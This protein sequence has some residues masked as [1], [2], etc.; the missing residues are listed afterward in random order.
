[1]KK[2]ISII[3]YPDG[4]INIEGI[5]NVNDLVR[6][7]GTSNSGINVS[8]SP[9]DTRRKRVVTMPYRKVGWTDEENSFILSNVNMEREDLSSAP[10]L[11]RH[12]KAAILTRI[13]AIRN[14]NRRCMSKNTINK[15]QD[16]GMYSLLKKLN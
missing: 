8:Y 1:M 13:S 15:M 11:S 12:S 10:E 4:Q 16:L 3:K 9:S 14:G 6:I 7:L 5:D 2:K